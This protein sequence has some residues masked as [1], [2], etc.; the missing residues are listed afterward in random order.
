MDFIVIF[1]MNVYIY[2]VVILVWEM[3]FM[4]MGLNIGIMVINIIVLL[5]QVGFCEEFWKVFGGVIIYDVFNWMCVIVLFFIEV[6][7]GYL[8]YLIKVIV[9]FFDI[10]GFLKMK[11]DLLKI[12][13][14]L[15]ICLFVQVD[16]Y[17]QLFLLLFILNYFFYF[18]ND[19]VF[20]LNELCLFF[21]RLIKL[22]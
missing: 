20:E 21:Y 22:C 3:I 8:F 11:R 5:V 12:I 2:L 13:I 7:F 17:Y 4:I 15:F 14:K 10:F 19:E 1:R 18:S 9:D 6:I 16:V